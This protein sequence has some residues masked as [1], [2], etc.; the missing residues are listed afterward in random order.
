[1]PASTP[2][3]AWAF[4]SSSAAEALLSSSPSPVAPFWICD[5]RARFGTKNWCSSGCSG[6]IALGDELLALL[7]EAVG[8]PLEEQQAEDEVLVV[9]A[10]DRA[11]QDVGRGPEV[12]FELLARELRTRVGRSRV[13]MPIPGAT[14][15]RLTAAAPF[16]RPR[17]RSS[18]VCFSRPLVSSPSASQTA[19]SSSRPS[20]P[21]TSAKSTRFARTMASTWLAATRRSA[22]SKS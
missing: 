1:M 15:S 16:E 10:V 22:T 20:R 18:S 12:A 4:A 9:A 2:S 19:F 14:S 6:S 8:Q 11:A 7:V 5:Q 17:T 13:G 21:S 3:S